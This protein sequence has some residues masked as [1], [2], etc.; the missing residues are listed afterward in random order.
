A[1]FLQPTA[2]TPFKQAPPAPPKPSQSSPAHPAVVA[3][4]ARDDD[5]DD[6]SPRT[7]LVDQD[8][9]ARVSAQA[10]PFGARPPQ[11]ATVAPTAP[12]AP[13]PPTASAGE[14]PASTGPKKFSI[15]VFASL[16][17]EIAENPSDADAIRQRYGISDSEH[18]AESGRW[19]AEFAQNAELRQR[20]LGI[21]QRYRGYIQQRKGG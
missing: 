21:V 4:S 3:P 5:D 2:A 13:L 8:L 11:P 6:D 19:T 16:T 10:T 15:N 12:T 18:R 14:G 7:K 1:T 9:V 20:Y 17:A